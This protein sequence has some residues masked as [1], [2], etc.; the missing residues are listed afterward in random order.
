MPSHGWKDGTMPEAWRNM[1]THKLKSTAT[2]REEIRSKFAEAEESVRDLLE[3]LGREGRGLLK[4]EQIER[5]LVRMRV[6]QKE[7]SDNFVALWKELDPKGTGGVSL[8]EFS[9]TF[10]LL[11]K[12]EEAYR[13][14]NERLGQSFSTIQRA[15]DE[16][17]VDG[18]GGGRRLGKEELK[19]H[20]HSMNLLQQKLSTLNYRDIYA[21]IDQDPSIP[22]ISVEEFAQNFSG[23][24]RMLPTARID[25]ASS[26]LKTLRKTFKAKGSEAWTIDG[27]CEEGNVCY[28]NGD[29][30]TAEKRYRAALRV[31][32][33]HVRT[34]C[35]LAWL[36]KTVKGDNH[37]AR[38]VI[39][40]AIEAEPTNPYVVMQETLY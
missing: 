12:M 10:G 17:G 31:D 18:D 16:W 11:S 28:A 22:T 39:R 26:N 37:A 4:K 38:G 33:K 13:V 34:L 9:R 25:T 8:S 24:A 19:R 20:L 23:A 27:M 15:F 1:E 35:S 6:V 36:L 40:R 32:P 30:E 3:R 5:L 14:C 21:A 7:G 29:Y 2:M